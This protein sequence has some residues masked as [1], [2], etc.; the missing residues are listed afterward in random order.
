MMN[1]RHQVN[2]ASAPRSGRCGT[3]GR[4]GEALRRASCS[5]RRYWPRTTRRIRSSSPVWFRPLGCLPVLRM[6]QN[7]RAK[8]FLLIILPDALIVN[9]TSYPRI[10]LGACAAECAN[11]RIHIDEATKSYCR[12]AAQSKTTLPSFAGT[13]QYSSQALFE[14]F[15]C[16]KAITDTPFA[17]GSTPYIR[18]SIQRRP[19]A[20]RAN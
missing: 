15:Y 8:P 11:R 10:A 5:E 13:P 14:Q 9:S 3:L 19:F 7:A 4:A 16:F 18:A 17:A 6:R 20:G 2:G 12:C 1:L